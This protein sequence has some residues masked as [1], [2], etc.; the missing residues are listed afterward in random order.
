MVMTSWQHLDTMDTSME[1]VRTGNLQREVV[2]SNHN[3]TSLII[4]TF[5]N[6]PFF[7][8]IIIS[9]ILI[10]LITTTTIK[11]LSV[12]ADIAKAWGV[13]IQ[14]QRLHRFHNCFLP[15]YQV[16][17]NDDCDGSG[18][19]DYMITRLY[20]MIV[21]MIIRFWLWQW[22]WCW[23]WSPSSGLSPMRGRFLRGKHPSAFW[24]LSKIQFCCLH[25]NYFS[26]SF[27][28]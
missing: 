28:L 6:L 5:I 20:E 13:F 22:W 21:I 11:I 19:Y 15:H 18:D 23:Q 8:I 24:L 16:Q 12:S 26:S 2:A 10:M 17:S 4:I 14:D 3:H 1:R 9:T 25:K 27:I 7:I